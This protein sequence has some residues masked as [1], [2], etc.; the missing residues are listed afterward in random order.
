MSYW[1]HCML[2]CGATGLA[3]YNPYNS[4]EVSAD[5]SSYGLGTVLQQSSNLEVSGIYILFHD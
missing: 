4:S 3:L 2:G 1:V 5:A